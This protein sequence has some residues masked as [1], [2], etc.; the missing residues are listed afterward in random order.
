LFR[1]L[2]PES[3]RKKLLDVRLL[4]AV[5]ALKEYGCVRAE[6][7][8]HLPA[9]TAGGARDSM[10]VRQ[11]NSSDFDF[12]SEFGYGGED[13]GA[14]RAVG[15]PVG[16]VLHIATGEHSTVRQEDRCTNPEFGIWSMCILHHSRCGLLQLPP[17]S[18]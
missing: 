1:S 3:F 11:R 4:R 8:N 14:L 12:W 18:R 9:G 6:L 16:G 5:G 13:C 10:I 7:V 15:H 17:D 2:E